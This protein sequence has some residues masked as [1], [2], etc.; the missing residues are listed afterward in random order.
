[1]PLK[2]RCPRCGNTD[3]FLVTVPQWFHCVVDS[4]GKIQLRLADYELY[5]PERDDTIECRGPADPY[6]DS[7]G[8][9]CEYRAPFWVFDSGQQGPGMIA[10]DYSAEHGGDPPKPPI[11]EAMWDDEDEAAEE[12]TP[13]GGP[14]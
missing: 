13:D 6:D 8:E 5:D 4:E 3:L 2:L 7:I 1:M 9:L 14:V 10:V 12:T 11:P